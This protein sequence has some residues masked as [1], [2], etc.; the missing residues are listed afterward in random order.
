MMNTP[1]KI[2][3]LAFIVSGTISLMEYVRGNQPDCPCGNPPNCPEHCRRTAYNNCEPMFALQF[4]PALNGGNT[5][6][7]DCYN[8]TQTECLRTTAKLCQG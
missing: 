2:F 4:S 1:V 3:L 6:F 7:T 5:G 8:K